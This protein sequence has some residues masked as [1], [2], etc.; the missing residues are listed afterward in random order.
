MINQKRLMKIEEAL[1]PVQVVLLLIQRSRETQSFYEYCSNI[2]S[3][4][5]SESPRSR[6]NTQVAGAVRN[7]MKGQPLELVQ[8]AVRSA[9]MEADFLVLLAFR[10]NEEILDD[11]EGRQLRLELLL[12]QVQH[13]G[14]DWNDVQ[15]L[16]WRER[17]ALIIFEILALKG[18]VEPIE[19][20]Y[21]HDQ[22]VLFGDAIQTLTNELALINEVCRTYKEVVAGSADSPVNLDA[23]WERCGQLV[24][25]R[26]RYLVACARSDMLREFAGNDAAANLIRQA[27]RELK[28]NLDQWLLQRGT[29]ASTTSGS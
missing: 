23:M 6:V 24:P 10:V 5:L 13:R 8:K 15:A 28:D 1:S 12:E 4:P 27:R 25:Y 17:L 9:A 3:L 22:R 14:A 26:S 7:G 2:A 19:R 18:M 11:S 21:F 29:Q 16:A 20:E